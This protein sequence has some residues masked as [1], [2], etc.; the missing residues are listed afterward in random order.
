MKFRTAQL[1]VNHEICEISTDQSPSRRYTWPPDLAYPILLN[2][3]LLLKS[4]IYEILLNVDS[5]S[6]WALVFNI[7]SHLYCRLGCPPAR[8]LHMWS[9]INIAN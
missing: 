5:L 6:P 2:Y 3:T 7:N 9:L 1:E 4:D 8:D